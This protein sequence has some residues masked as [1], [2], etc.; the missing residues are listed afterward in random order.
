MAWQ[1]DAGDSFPEYVVNTVDGRTLKVPQDLP[2]EYA[3]LLFYR[4]SW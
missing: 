1:L 2:G 3:V 4:G